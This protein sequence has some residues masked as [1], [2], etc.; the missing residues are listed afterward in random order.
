MDQEKID[1][2]DSLLLQLYIFD[3]REI[4]ELREKVPYM[5]EEGVDKLI[6]IL[7]KGVKE[8]EKMIKNW[9]KRQPDFAKKLADFASEKA[10]KLMKE[11]EVMEKES[12]EDILSEI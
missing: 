10:V 8:Q 11:G 12:A 7:K 2:I 6:T 5:K 9:T 4:D 3:Q 1:I